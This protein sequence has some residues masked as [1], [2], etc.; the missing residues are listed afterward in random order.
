MRAARQ[1]RV[2]QE[3]L[4][5]LKE[6]VFTHLVQ[7]LARDGRL[8]QILEDILGKKTD[9]YSA[10]EEFIRKVLGSQ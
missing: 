9:P 5:L 1:E 7:K 4:E 6:G 2:R 3:F 10:S 8:D